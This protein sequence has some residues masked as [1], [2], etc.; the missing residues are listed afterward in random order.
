MKIIYIS[1]SAIPSSSPN[2]IHVMKM[3]QAF[4]EL[5]HEVALIGK[6]TTACLKEVTD[7]HRFY[8]VK[9]NF[10]LKV[11]PSKA[12]RG[13]GAY[14]NVSLGWRVLGL[15]ADLIYTRSITAAFFLLLFGRAVAFE[16]HEPFEGKGTRLKKMFRFIVHHKKLV[17]LVVIS[18]AL[19][20]YYRNTFNMAED[21]IFVAHDG[22]DPFPPA[23]PVLKNDGFK[24]GYV[25]S[26]YPGKGMEILI[27][28]AEQ[29]PQIQFHILGGNSKQIAENKDRAKGLENLFFH[30]FKS[31]QELPSYVI[32]F[33]AVIAPY[34]AYIK[35]SEK[36]GANN[37]ALWMSPLKIFEYMSSGKAII[38]SDLPVIREILEHGQNAL[39]CDP[40][41]LAQWRSAA[42]RLSNDNGLRATLSGNALRLF[43]EQY[44]WRKRAE[45]IL[46]AL[47]IS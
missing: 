11:F 43:T 25:G 29:C 10:Q 39:L 23:S 31:Q 34:T 27:P 16:V 13:S 44:T 35:V 33:D 40:A 2:S 22:A 38:T 3:C 5:G 24:I 30:G 41:D 46:N 6:N 12:F 42:V 1:D 8:A 26:L 28:L 9:K 7:I 37:L 47:R 19:K 14:Y 36:T 17:K 4:A 18:A 21:D 15:Q 20:D 32:S 45:H